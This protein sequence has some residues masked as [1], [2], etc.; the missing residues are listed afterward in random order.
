MLLGFCRFVNACRS[1]F[2]F[3]QAI[4]AFTLGVEAGT[5]RDETADNHVLF[6]AAE[7]VG[8]ATDGS[9]D[10]HAGGVLEGG[11]GQERVTR[12]RDFRNW[13]EQ[14]R[15]RGSDFAFAFEAL[16]VFNDGL[17]WDDFAGN[18]Q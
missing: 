8:L 18:K 5:D 11:S 10:K 14:L 6:E 3:G 12:E 13:Q 17:A 16:V 15:E 9:G 2:G 1:S 4:F 7:L